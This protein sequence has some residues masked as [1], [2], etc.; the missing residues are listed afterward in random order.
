MSAVMMWMLFG[1]IGV[2][3][4]TPGGK[5]CAGKEKQLEFFFSKAEQKRS[6]H[7]EMTV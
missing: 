1:S 6:I 4:R 3:M 7:I 2:I 5:Q